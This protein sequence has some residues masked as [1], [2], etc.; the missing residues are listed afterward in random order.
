MAKP[1]VF[2]GVLADA[3]GA[4]TKTR[5]TIPVSAQD[6]WGLQGRFVSW[7]GYVYDA[8]YLKL[9]EATLTYAFPASLLGRTKFISGLSL[10]LYGRNLLTYAPNFPDLDPEQNLTGVSNARG[11]EFGIQPIAR[12]AGLSLRATF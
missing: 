8:T 4:P 10:S 2:D 6:Y 1:W 5:N 3:S 9:R 7:E 11:L 12:T